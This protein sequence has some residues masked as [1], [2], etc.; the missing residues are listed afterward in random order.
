MTALKRLGK[1]AAIALA[2]LAL[3]WGASLFVGNEVI[4]PSPTEVVFRLFELA[5]VGTFWQ[6]ILYSVI[7]II[8]GLICASF[9]ALLLAAAA[10]KFKLT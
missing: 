6:S 4:L 3:W 2:W 1:Y 10:F 8:F 7:R 9:A 5:A